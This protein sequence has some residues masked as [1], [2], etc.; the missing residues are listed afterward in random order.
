LPANT[1]IAVCQRSL[2]ERVRQI[3]P[4]ARVYEVDDYINAP[5]YGELVRTL[6]AAVRG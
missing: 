3:A 2:A 6:V 1:Q 4:Q 5:A